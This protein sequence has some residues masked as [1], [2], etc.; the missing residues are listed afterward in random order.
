MQSITRLAPIDYL[1][2][3]HI[4]RDMTPGGPKMGGTTYAALTARML[5]LRVG[6]ITSW[7]EEMP[8]GLMADVSIVNQPSDQ[9]TTFENI[10]TPNGRVQLIHHQAGT[11]DH[12][13]LPAAWV[14]TP[15]VHL[16]PVAQEVDPD[17]ATHFPHS[18]VGATP[19]GWMRSW[20]QEGHIIPTRWQAASQVL[21]SVGVTILSIEDVGG[22]EDLIQEMAAQCPIFVV[23]EGYYGA[24]CTGMETSVVSVP[25][26]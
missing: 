7:G 12:R 15:V 21:K 22:N 20:D 24:G 9:S 10:Y 23:T 5:G 1:V 18:L 25:H 17:L 26:G 11:L 3:G 8:L 14:Y 16:G 13:S 2:I 4:T 19:Q 6:V